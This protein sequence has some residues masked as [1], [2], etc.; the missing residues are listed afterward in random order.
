M[1]TITESVDVHVPVD[2]AYKVHSTGH[3]DT[4]PAGQHGPDA[5]VQVP[6][7]RRN[8]QD[9]EFPPGVHGIE[10]RTGPGA[11]RHPV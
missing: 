11:A 10:S 3:V 1:S 9:T 4:V 2:E 7:L 5:A 8:E 6:Q